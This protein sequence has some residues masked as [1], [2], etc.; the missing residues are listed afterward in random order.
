MNCLT[1]SKEKRLNKANRLIQQLASDF[2]LPQYQV[3]MAQGYFKLAYKH[4][5]V[6][7]RRTLHV[8]AAVLYIVCRKEKVPLLLIDFSASLHV[9]QKFLN[10]FNFF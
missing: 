9:I 4:N 7:G 2:N 3:D 8:A 10:I 1:D 6:K 5:F